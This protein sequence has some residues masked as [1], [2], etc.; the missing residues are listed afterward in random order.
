M[1]AARNLL[2]LGSILLVWGCGDDPEPR[3][4]DGG[5]GRGD[6]SLTPP[7]ATPPRPDGGE[8]ICCPIGAPSCDCVATGGWAP[9]LDACGGQVCDGLWTT[10]TDEHGCPIL[11]S[12]GF[13]AFVPDAGPPGPDGGDPC[14]GAAEGLACAAEGT[15][16]GGPCTDV[17]SFCNLLFCS[18]GRWQRLEAFPAPCFAC[19]D[20]RCQEQEQYCTVAHSDVGGEPDGYACQ[21]T[22]EA[23]RAEPTCACLGAQGLGF[24]RCTD[25]VA[26]QVT[27]EWFGG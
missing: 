21:P 2:A 4:T 25:D 9:S 27:L 13:C 26:G 19:G 11:R 8:G 12:D 3:A 5:G 10:G 1:Y 24:D 7:D 15:S 23:C 14:A 16:C 18:D 17:C 20:Q 6:G 22:P